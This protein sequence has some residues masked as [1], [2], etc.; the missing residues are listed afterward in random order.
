VWGRREAAERAIV[1]LTAERAELALQVSASSEAA[2]AAAAAAAALLREQ[3][4]APP[5]T[6][7]APTMTTAATETT[8]AASTTPT[9]TVAPGAAM[10]G[11]A[12]ATA[13]VDGNAAIIR[14]LTPVDIDTAPAAWPPPG[15]GRGTLALPAVAP[16][17]GADDG[18]IISVDTSVS[19]VVD[20]PGETGKTPA[21]GPAFQTYL[22]PR[23]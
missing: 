17:G 13:T 10:T 4:E 20:A 23:P 16:A 19:S 7:A 2:A 8:M 22:N 11:A 18:S 12:A 3:S 1:T 9:T 6:T 14:R 15:P 21:A 5:A